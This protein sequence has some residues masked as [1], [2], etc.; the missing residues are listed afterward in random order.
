MKK[1]PWNLSPLFSPH[2]IAIVGAS[3]RD[4][5][6]SLV[7]KNLQR[8]GFKGTIYPVNPKYQQIMGYPC[9]PSLEAIPGPVDCAALLLGGNAIL[10][11]LKAAHARGI[12]GTWAFASGFAEMGE[13]GKAKQQ[14]LKAFCEETGLLFCGPNCVGYANIAEGI[15]MYSAPLPRAFHKG[16]IGVIAQSGAVLLALG[17]AAREVGFSR[18]IS[19]GNEASLGLVD[20]LDYLI[21]DPCT[22]VIALFIETIRDPDGMA[23]ACCR[24]QAAKKP[25]IA[26]KVGR[27]ELA[28]RVAATHTGAIAGS[29]RILDAFFRR[30]NVVRVNTLDQ[31]LE[32]A[33][34]FSKFHAYPPASRRIG[35]STVSGGEMGM[36]A[37]LVADHGLEFPA[38]SEQ[39]KEA[40]RKVLPPYTPIANPLDAWGSGDLKESYPASVSILANEPDVDLLVVSQDIPANMADDQ[41]AQFSDVA[42]AA[43]QARKASGKPVVLMSNI[44]GGIDASIQHILDEGGIPVLQ[45]SDESLGAIASWIDWSRAEPDPEVTAPTISDSLLAELDQCDGILPYTTATRLLAHF[46]ITDMNERLVSTL[47]QAASAASAIGYPVVL[48]VI[49]RDIPHKTESGLVKLHINDEMTLNRAWQALQQALIT[50]HPTARLEGILVQKMVSG[51]AVETIVGVNRDGQF[52]SAVV[53]GLGGIFVELMRDASLELAPLSEAR[54]FAM[55]EKLRAA[56]LLKGF[57]GSRPSDIPALARLLVRIGQLAHALGDRLVSLDLN[58]VMV[59]PETQGV[60][61][62]DIVIQ[63]RTATPS[64]SRSSS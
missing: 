28:C 44:S 39:G 51:G 62:V 8:L 37:D 17:N 53:V 19:S 14:E 54:A 58:P 56:K 18:L 1:S 59:L 38:L 40:L 43:V 61:I 46:G 10:P 13:E 22:D 16:N 34:L 33:I 3:P 64:S 6:G 60:R 31:L 36:L 47:E 2:S 55:V 63:T 29:D 12:K 48:K 24:A 41:I 15:G 35:M 42:R 49:S 32:T 9:Y 20:Y 21:D 23:A 25:V 30:W 26:L 7:I 5:A 4:G 11:Q 52:G 45:G 50:H 57:R 27:S